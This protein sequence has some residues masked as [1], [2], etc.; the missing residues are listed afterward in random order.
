MADLDPRRLKE[1]LS[2][3]WL[4]LNHLYKIVDEDGHEVTYKPN[5][6][7][8]ELFRDPHPRKLVLKARQIGYTTGIDID[9]LDW[10]TF[11]SNQTVGI[12]AHT[13]EDATK[14][15]ERKIRYAYDRLPIELRKLLKGRTERKGELEFSNGSI[16]YVSTSFR[17]GTLQ[18]L[19]VSEM[20]KLA[21]MYPAKAREVVDGAFPTVPATGKIFVESTA[22]GSAGQFYDLAKAAMDDHRRGIKLNPLAFKFFF[23]AWWQKPAYRLN[24]DA[25]VIPARLHQYFNKLKKQGIELDDAQ[26]AWYT[27]MER[28]LGSRMFKEH[29]SIPEEAFTAAIKGAY[30][31]F[32]MAQVRESGR[33]CKLP[34]EPG[35]PVHTNWDLGIDD[36]TAIWFYQTLGRSVH[37]VD[38]YEAKDVG[39]SHYA[40]VLRDKARDRGFNY[41]KHFWPHDGRNRNLATGKRL[42][43]TAAELGIYPITIM[44]NTP[45]HDQIEAARKI[46]A[47]SWFDEE[48][49]ERGVVALDNYRK[50]WN[51]AI[52]SYMA[53]P[54]HDWAS[55]PADAFMVGAV[56]HK[57]T[58]DGGHA[59]PPDLPR[60]AAA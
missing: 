32:E 53:T 37:W 34:P 14:I 21:M 39:L 18:F 49:T 46:L 42:K 7:Q 23:R 56:T 30:F 57:W 11:N 17:S 35:A 2:D 27:A 48:H 28:T 3:R 24:P 44:P 43:D 19:H 52:G 58:A 40:D 25:V 15:F 4:R 26:K 54:A 1:F 33:I 5:A 12:I 38:Y 45:K 9:G 60:E 16:I 50:Q 55:H 29:P 6:A 10:A 20:G 22:E 59:F 36:H 13:K 51:Q 31:A 41:G 8:A 47:R